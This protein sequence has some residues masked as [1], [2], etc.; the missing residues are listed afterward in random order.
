MPVIQVKGRAVHY[1]QLN[2]QAADTVLLVHGMFSNLA[3]YYFHIAPILAQH[4]RV[5]MY[6]MKG[7]GMS[8][9]AES[10]YDL[11]AMAADMQALMQV[12][13][14]PAVHL[15][16]YSFGALVA[17][18]AALTYPKSIRRLGLI[19]GPD[20]ADKR[21]LEGI[22]QY[23]R[24][25]LLDYVDKHDNNTLVTGGKRKLEKMH[26]RFEY[27]FH[28]TT[29][30]KDMEKEHA[31]FEDTAIGALPHDTLLMY[32]RASDCKGAGELLH[33]RIRKSDLVLIDGDHTVPVQ[34]PALI[35]NTLT[36]FFNN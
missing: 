13:E 36:A 3:V 33:N 27:L 12:L 21:M 4:F 23:N 18:K 25:M 10:G 16:G 2:E 31:F 24:D 28:E 32:G 29:I 34:Q 20:P 14:L 5:V 26:R 15:A 6:D 19:E 30:R 17:L 9:R 11:D 8:D 35:G 22:A 1:Q 7:H